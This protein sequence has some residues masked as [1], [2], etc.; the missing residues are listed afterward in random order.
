LPA[1][2]KR[3]RFVGYELLVLLAI[4]HQGFYSYWFCSFDLDEPLQTRVA[5]SVVDGWGLT[6]PRLN[7][8]DL[9]KP[10][11]SPLKD[12]LAGYPRVLAAFLFL[13]NDVW[14]AAIMVD[15]LSAV[16]FFSAWYVIIEMF[17]P[18]VPTGAKVLLWS[19]WALVWNPLMMMYGAEQL[20]QALF[21]WGIVLCL[22]CVRAGRYRMVCATACALCMGASAACRFAYW[23]LLLVAPGAVF[24]AAFAGNRKRELIKAACVIGATSA[25]LLLAVAVDHWCRTGQVTKAYPKTGFFWHNLSYFNPFPAHLVGFPSFWKHVT[26]TATSLRFISPTLLSWMVSAVVVVLMAVPL[27]RKWRADKGRF[28]RGPEAPV[29]VAFAAAAGL[30]IGLTVSMLCYLSVR[31]P[32]FAFWQGSVWTFVAETR[33]YAVFFGFLSLA[34]A[35]SMSTLL[36]SAFQGMQIRWTRGRVLAG[37]TAVVVLAVAAHV[38]EVAY[39]VDFRGELAQLVNY[40]GKRTQRSELR[41]EGRTVHAAVRRHVAAGRSVLF[42]E[43]ENEDLQTARWWRYA[44]MA[45][46]FPVS[47]KSLLAMKPATTDPIAMLVVVPGTRSHG[48]SDVAR[49]I[50][51]E[52]TRLF[53]K[54]AELSD[55]EL[56]EVELA[57]WSA[58]PGGEG[59]KHHAESVERS[60]GL[61]ADAAPVHP[62]RNCDGD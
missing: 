49:A 59:M 53:H 50:D 27:I 7:P 16:L 38:T 15:V 41:R 36:A 28:V 35:Y 23:P 4:L 60:P 43:W 44:R 32:P 31:K 24:L 62:G 34:L 51:V 40:Q 5:Q 33:Y 45:G 47:M 6:S 10:A 22:G 55:G 1:E 39:I 14:T 25:I 37:A 26:G 3:K 57:R 61:L 19:Y 2:G 56:Y 20:S 9:S 11:R 8:E 48:L 30:T 21:S 52:D 42:V 46:G 13:S 18:R 29:I 58:G 17:R 54:I 12:W